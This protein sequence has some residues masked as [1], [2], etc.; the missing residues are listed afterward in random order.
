MSTNQ[1]I[2]RL[3]TSVGSADEQLAAGPALLAGLAQTGLLA[4]RWYRID[5]PAL[6]LGSAQ[7][8]HEADL[9]AC[10]A[11]GVSVHRRASGGGIVLS[12]AALLLL[13]LALPERHSLFRHDV[14]ESYRWFGE[15]WAAGLRALALDAQ[16]LPI[17][18][19]RADTQALDP[20]L[21]RVCF[22]GR[23][24]YEVMVGE[25]K[26][27]GLAQIRRRG[28][29]LFQAGIYLRWEPW[30]TAALLSATEA[31]RAALAARLGER[32][33]GLRELTGGPLLNAAT[34]ME[35][36]EGALARFAHLAP[37]DDEWR[38]DERSA[39]TA[40]LARYAAISYPPSQR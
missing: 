40:A 13:D 25:R 5:P 34:V 31:E 4:L 2:R 7:Q 14:T 35:A 27:V 28:G 19:A 39:Q 36:V 8:P 10:A 33:V 16:I 21:K 23:S 12:D 6:L 32:V 24:P 18:M 29:A 3:P 1:T 26:L 38:A 20:L 15:V 11:A 30:G 17:A 37:V 22:G 9:E